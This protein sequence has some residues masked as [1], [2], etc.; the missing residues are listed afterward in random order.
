MPTVEHEGV[1]FHY[2]VTGEG[3]AVALCH[4]LCGELSHVRDVVGPLPG[5]RTVLWDA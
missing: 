1:L 2:E 3:P 4:G 5:Y